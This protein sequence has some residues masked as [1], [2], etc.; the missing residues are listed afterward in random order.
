MLDR[1]EALAPH[2]GI[3]HHHRANV[4]YLSGDRDGAVAALRRALE[5]E[6]DNAVL[7][8]NLASLDGGQPAP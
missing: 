3:V 6:P 7:R 2:L 5:L 4:A 8:A 1:A